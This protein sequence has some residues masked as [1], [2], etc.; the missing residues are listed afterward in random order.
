MLAANTFAQ[1]SIQPIGGWREH[2][3][4]GSTID[5]TASPNKIYAA[6][7]YSLFSVDLASK[8][9]ERISRISGLSETGIST[10]KFNAAE[11]QLFVAYTN[12]NIDVIT[13]SGIKNIP[14]L[15]RETI[16]GDKEYISY[17]PGSQHLLFINRYWYSGIKY[18]KIRDQRYLAHRKRWWL[19]KN[20]HVVKGCAVLLCSYRR[21]IKKSIGNYAKPGGLYSLAKHFRKQWTN[22]HFL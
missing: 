10:I 17:L 7:P 16:A 8:E 11:N 4:Y 5:V 15:K 12:S 6:T 9:I 20:L 18:F 19:C 3:P 22:G 21:R 14:E 13:N 2:L 1:S